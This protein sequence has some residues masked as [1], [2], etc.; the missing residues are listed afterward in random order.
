MDYDDAVATFYAP[1]PAD[2][3]VPEAVRGGGPARRLRD[4]CEPIAMHAVWN[5]LTIE[6]LAA[7]GLDFL[8]SYVGGRAASLGEPSPP[9]VAATFAWFEPNLIANGRRNRADCAHPRR[10]AAARPSGTPLATALGQS[11]PTMSLNPCELEI[12]LF[13]RGVRIDADTEIDGSREIARTR[14]GLGS[15]LELVIPTGSWL[16]PEIWVN[17][18][19]V[20]L[21]AA[22]LGA[23]LRLYERDWTGKS[24]SVAVA[25]KV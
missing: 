4:A 9:V 11:V 7:L 21:I 19:V 8:A 23:P 3:P 20:E 6:R 1:R 18:P 22:P 16:K 12:D 13:C 10:R 2:T 5:R 24:E 14:A 15:G 25:V 17:A